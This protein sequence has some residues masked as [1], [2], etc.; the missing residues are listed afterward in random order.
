MGLWDAYYEQEQATS[1]EKAV[2]DAVSCLISEDRDDD[3]AFELHSKVGHKE[4]P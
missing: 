4:L 1:Y 3:V 2:F